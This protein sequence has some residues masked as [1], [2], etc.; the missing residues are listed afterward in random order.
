VKKHLTPIFRAL[1]VTKRPQ[2]AVIGQVLLE[3]ER[4]GDVTSDQ[5]SG[6]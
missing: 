4:R 5:R 2:A 1:A 6:S 3:G